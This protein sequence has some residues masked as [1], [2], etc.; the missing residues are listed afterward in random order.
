MTWLTRSVPL[1]R[2]SRP[3]L[4]GAW[5]RRRPL[6]RDARRGRLPR[7]TRPSVGSVIRSRWRLRWRGTRGAAEGGLRATSARARAASL[8][9]HLLELSER[10]LDARSRGLFVT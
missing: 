6:A 1:A 7:A 10:T 4:L 5:R 8:L 3:R 9:R 2:R